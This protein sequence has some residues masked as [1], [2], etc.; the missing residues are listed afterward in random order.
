MWR[1]FGLAICI[2]VFCPCVDHDS[3]FAQSAIDNRSSWEAE[4]IVF[5]AAMALVAVVAVVDAASRRFGRPLSPHPAPFT[6]TLK[7]ALSALLVLCPIAGLVDDARAGKGVLIGDKLV[8]LCAFGVLS[9]TMVFMA[10]RGHARGTMVTIAWTLALVMGLPRLVNASSDTGTRQVRPVGGGRFFNTAS[11][12]PPCVVARIGYPHPSSTQ[13]SLACS[14]LFLYYS[15]ISA[16]A[17][18]CCCIVRTTF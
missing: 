14:P 16:C 9:G 18:A 6:S 12:S 4:A 11:V 15:W 2:G 1:R 13:C 17:C 5:D 10:R 7:I 8:L 3:P